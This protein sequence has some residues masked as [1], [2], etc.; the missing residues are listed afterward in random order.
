M[1]NIIFIA[2]PAA[3][4]GTFSTLLE[5]KYQ[6]VHISTGDLLRDA[7]K[8]EDEL[9]QKITVLMNS[10]KLVSDDIVL[11]LL[12][13]FFTSI[14]DKNFILDGFPRNL[15]QAKVL[16]ELLLTLPENDYVVIY[17]DINY[18]IALK[19]TLGRIT[20]PNC[21][22]SYNSYFEELKPKV[23]GICDHC[24][25]EL[26]KRNDDTEETFKIRFDTYLEET[27]PS[28]DYYKEKDKLVVIDA[29]LGVENILKEIERVL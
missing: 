17:L 3:G 27:K 11:E 21:K 4:K 29:T 15:N 24:K 20:C 7:M 1:K 6:Y 9:G 18:E 14:E 2:P 10:G 16:D 5:D 8:K 23:E 19:R 25:S 22:R 28:L 13:N 26:V 12:Q